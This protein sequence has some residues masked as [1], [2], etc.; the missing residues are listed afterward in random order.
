MHTVLY[1]RLARTHPTALGTGSVARL[2][3]TRSGTSRQQVRVPETDHRMPPPARQSRTGPACGGGLSPSPGLDTAACCVCFLPPGQSLGPNVYARPG[4]AA[5][6][7][8]PVLPPWARSPPPPPLTFRR[9]SGRGRSPRASPDPSPGPRVGAHYRPCPCPRGPAPFLTH[10]RPPQLPALS[11]RG[12]AASSWPQRPRRH[13]A[14]QPRTPLSPTLWLRE[15]PLLQEG[16]RPAHHSIQDS[17]PPGAPDSGPRIPAHTPGDRPVDPEPPATYRDTDT[18]RHSLCPGR[19]LTPRSSASLLRGHDPSTSTVLRSAR[20][21]CPPPSGRLSL[22]SDSP[23][24]SS[25]A[26]PRAP[27]LCS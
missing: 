26:S 17:I 8:S 15:Q 9:T 11:P 25:P 22:G 7:S 5:D 16:V 13:R 2:L 20:T 23:P 14:P 4:S 27:T 6:P 1:A 10:S 3:P 24:P 12:V 18:P 19:A 21:V